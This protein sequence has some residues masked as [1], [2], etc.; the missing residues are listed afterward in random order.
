VVFQGSSSKLSLGR[1]WQ[2]L[3]VLGSFGQFGQIQLPW[4]WLTTSP[5]LKGKKEYVATY[6]KSAIILHI[7][8]CSKAL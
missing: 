1:F 8:A 7:L 3:A 5:H 2:N 6:T 4:Q